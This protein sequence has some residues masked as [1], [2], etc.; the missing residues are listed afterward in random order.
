[1]AR[2]LDQTARDLHFD[3]VV[4]STEA[5]RAREDGDRARSETLGEKAVG[6][7]CAYM[8]HLSG[9]R[10]SQNHPSPNLLGPSL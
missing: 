4:F 8:D 3:A 6:R 10:A 9:V 5:R 2:Y 7:W 1:M